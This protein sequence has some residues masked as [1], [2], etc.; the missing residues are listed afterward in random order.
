MEVIDKYQLVILSADYIFI[1]G[2]P[3]FNTYS[4]DID[5]ITSRR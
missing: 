1:N 5:F 3:L 4:H 2:V